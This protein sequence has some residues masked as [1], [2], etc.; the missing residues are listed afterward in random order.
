MGRKRT[1][2][3]DRRDG[4]LGIRVPVTALVKGVEKTVRLWVE[5]DQ[6]LTD[7]QARAEAKALTDHF[8]G[9]VVDPKQVYAALKGQRVTTLGRFVEEVYLPTRS[10]QKSFRYQKSAWKNHILPVLGRLDVHTFEAD[11]LRGLVEHLDGLAESEGSRFSHK[12]AVNVWGLVTKFCSDLVSSKDSRIRC[13]KDNPCTNVAGPDRGDTK[14]LQWLYPNELQTLLECEDIPVI[15]RRRYALYT[16][17]FCRAGELPALDF[18]H[19]IDLEHGM[20]TI[21]R[22]MN[23]RAQTVDLFT[24]ADGKSAMARSFPIEEILYPLLRVMRDENGAGER[25]LDMH[26]DGAD[27]LRGDL[28]TAGVRRRA[29][30]EKTG[31]HALKIRLHDLRATGITYLAIRGHTDNEIRDRAGHTD[32]KMTSV[33]IRRG[34]MGSKLIGEPFQ[35]LPESLLRQ[36][37]RQRKPKSSGE[38]SMGNSENPE[39]SRNSGLSGVRRKG[40]EPFE[41]ASESQKPLVSDRFSYPVVRFEDE[42]GQLIDDIQDDIGFEGPD[43]PSSVDAYTLNTESA[44]GAKS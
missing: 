25:I 2:T 14:Q 22:K 15:R 23:L 20:V 8:A 40:L 27:Q 21:D 18:E 37:S 11:H 10:A 3:I 19:N 4:V 17:L 34:R 35:P 5:V 36:D 42:S 32:F 6:S 38:S 16:Y 44:G 12:S 39:S 30:H 41:A 31:K 9:R 7:E 26:D 28:W 33:Y 24:K 1:G 43:G 13:R 29:L